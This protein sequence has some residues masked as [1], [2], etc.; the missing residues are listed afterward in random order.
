MR[1][2]PG[3]DILASVHKVVVGL[4]KADLADEMLRIAERITEVD[5]ARTPAAS[6]RSIRHLHLRR[7]LR[8]YF[9]PG[10]R[11][12]GSREAGRQPSG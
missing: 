9:T 11:S 6:M 8:S 7:S 1:D 12:R 4:H 5:R 2:E 10:D 3:S